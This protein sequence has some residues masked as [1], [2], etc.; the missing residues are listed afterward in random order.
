MEK[1]RTDHLHF[2]GEGDYLATDRLA[3]D[4]TAMVPDDW[5]TDLID[6]QN[7]RAANTREYT[8]DWRPN[9][10]TTKGQPNDTVFASACTFWHV[11]T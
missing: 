5:M 6:G 9:K 7:R 3:L 2:D 4:T 1:W 10:A 8:C 11:L